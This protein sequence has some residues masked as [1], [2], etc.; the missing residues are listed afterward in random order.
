MKSS[1]VRI[2]PVITVSLLCLGSLVPAFAE[3][4]TTSVQLREAI[5]SEIM[6]DPRSASLTPAQLDALVDTLTTK[7]SSQG[8][9]AQQI[10]WHPGIVPMVAT[11]TPVLQ[12][13]CSES[14]VVCQISKA[15]GATIA[16]VDLTLLFLVILALLCLGLYFKM[17]ATKTISAPEIAPM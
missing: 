9:T 2:L 4:A 15:T 1:L 6:Q 17:R 11:T 8:V 13:M 3:T 12:V 16:A 5:R 10:S 7:A 14:D